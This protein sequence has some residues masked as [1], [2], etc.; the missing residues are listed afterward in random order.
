MILVTFLTHAN[1]GV[2][3]QVMESNL[4]KK[5]QL[6]LKFLEHSDLSDQIYS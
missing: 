3:Y 4:G 5:K 6:E 2:Y 1:S